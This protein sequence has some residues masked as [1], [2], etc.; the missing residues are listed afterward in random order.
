MLVPSISD[1]HMSNVSEKGNKYS[2]VHT[3][4]HGTLYKCSFVKN[5]FV[6]VFSFL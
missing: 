4:A 6:Y 3:Q 1:V 2:Q 5:Q